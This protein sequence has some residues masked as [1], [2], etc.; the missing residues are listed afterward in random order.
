MNDILTKADRRSQGGVKLAGSSTRYCSYDRFF[1]APAFTGDVSGVSPTCTIC[2]GSLALNSEQELHDVGGGVEGHAVDVSILE[3]GVHVASIDLQGL[4]DLGV[5]YS[6]LLLETDGSFPAETLRL[7]LG[8]DCVVSC[9]EGVKDFLVAKWQAGPVQFARIIEV[10]SLQYL[11]DRS[12][13]VNHTLIIQ[14]AFKP[15]GLA[16]CERIEHQPLAHS[17]GGSL[18]EV[19]Q[20]AQVESLF[21]REVLELS[22][23]PT[24][25]SRASH[26]SL[27]PRCAPVA[28]ALCLNA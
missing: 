5:R 15:A 20:A 11:L 19:C 21:S 13:F 28:S 17:G 8:V 24:F 6:L 27:H 14:N 22:A 4:V 10:D 9:F 1:P 23:H 12:Q 26:C 3:V 2:C 18:C 7:V 16:R 25:E